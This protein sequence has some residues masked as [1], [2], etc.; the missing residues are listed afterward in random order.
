M[1]LTN[2]FT[3]LAVSLT[4]SSAWGVGLDAAAQKWEKPFPEPFKNVYSDD[5]FSSPLMN[6]GERYLD[7][8]RF[9][10]DDQELAQVHDMQ[11]LKDLGL[12]QGHFDPLDRLRIS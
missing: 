6:G 8:N 10:E 2:A 1:S 4:I 3:S 7:S 5:G 12:A 9:D 11:Q